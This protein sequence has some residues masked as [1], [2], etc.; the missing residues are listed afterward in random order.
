MVTVKHNRAALVHLIVAITGIAGLG[1]DPGWLSVGNRRIQVAAA[2]ALVLG[3][4][5]LGREKRL[6]VFS[7]NSRRLASF[8]ANWYRKKGELSVFCTD[9]EWIDSPE[10]VSALILKAE[11]GHLCLYLRN[12]GPL[13]ERLR[14]AKAKVYRIPAS[15]TSPHRFSILQTDGFERIICRNKA[16]EASET[17]AEKIEFIETTNAREPYLI[18]M[19]RDVISSCSIEL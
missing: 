16:I 6:F 7:A 9:L 5:I 18:A 19:A 3:A 1:L 13:A 14:A 2:L 10:I 8:F 17:K 4:F 15:I 12:T 11:G